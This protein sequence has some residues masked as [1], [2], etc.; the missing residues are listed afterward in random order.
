MKKLISVAAVVTLTAGLA[1]TSPLPAQAVLGGELEAMHVTASRATLPDTATGNLAGKKLNGLREWRFYLTNGTSSLITNPSIVVDSGLAPGDFAWTDPSTPGGP[2]PVTAFPTTMPNSATSLDPC[3]NLWDCQ[4]A[5]KLGDGKGLMSTHAVSFTAGYDSTRTV[6]PTTI[7][8]GG[9]D[10]T[11]VVTVTPRDV[12]YTSGMTCFDV[13]FGSN[14]PGVTY[15]SHDASD[16]G[17]MY[18]TDNTAINPNGIEQMRLCGPQAATGALTLGQTYTFTTTYSV[19]NPY[20]QPFRFVPE[21]GINGQSAVSLASVVGDSVTMLDSTLSGGKGTAFRQ[22]SSTFTV[23]GS[24]T[25]GV[26]QAVAA[27]VS[28]SG[29]NHVPSTPQNVQVTLRDTG[30]QVTWAPPLSSGSGGQ[31]SGY[32]VRVYTKASK[33]RLVASFQTTQTQTSLFAAPP[34]ASGTQY[35]VEV[36]AMNPFGTSIPST[37]RFPFTLP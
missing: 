33:G 35:W 8:V 24:H 34:L 15:L 36:A 4:T 9:G 6:T 1:L 16:P 26:N 7:P 25:W 18:P 13:I 10:Q 23:D 31:L 3:I 37:P 27:D 11:T 17:T 19:P 30:A 22:G 14:L 20:G 5:S 28:Y 21:I 29:T 2:V 32:Q 12:R